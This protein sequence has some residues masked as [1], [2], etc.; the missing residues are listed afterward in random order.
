MGTP[1]LSCM[2]I[3]YMIKQE[4]TVYGLLATIYSVT[5]ATMW[6]GLKEAFYM[7]GITGLSVLHDTTQIICL[8]NLGYVVPQVCQ[9][10]VASREGLVS[11]EYQG[12][13]AMEGGQVCCWKN[14]FPVADRVPCLCSFRRL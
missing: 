11:V 2:V 10:Y 4:D 13:Q 6:D 9:G 7:T 1:R 8:Q 3:V 14:I 5:T 12:V